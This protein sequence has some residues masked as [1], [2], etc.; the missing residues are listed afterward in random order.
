MDFTSLNETD[1]REEIIAPLIR[2][3]GYR[4]ATLHNVLREQ[5]LRYPRIYIGRKDEK[6][7]PPLRGKADYILEAGGV[8]RWVIEA[9]A[10]TCTI[11]ADEIE[12]AWTYANHP[13]VCA[14]YFSLCNGKRLHIYQT[15]RGP[16][17]VPILS[18]EYE[19]LS[20]ND[21]KAVLSNLLSPA[22]IL[23]DHPA[24]IVDI[25]PPIGPGL[26]SIARVTSG[27]FSYDKS[28][29][30]APAL[31]ELQLAIISGAV[32]R[33][34]DNRLVAF[35]E[36]RGPSRSIQ[37]FSER[38]GLSTFEMISNDSTFSTDTTHP[39][40]FTYSRSFIFPAGEE[41]LDMNTWQYVTL[42]S[43][44]SVKF[45]VTA[46]GILEGNKFHGTFSNNM[47]INEVM[48]IDLEGR[49]CIYVS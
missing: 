7:D 28:T 45:T 23:K 31:R 27:H 38:M 15:N 16:A 47:V 36:S 43:N 33:D 4:S 37:E 48:P 24:Q 30:E 1:V 19:Q 8:V 34:S 21:T 17:S 22:S 12:Q 44:M 49:F 26:R 14:V 41:L 35:L 9:K 18:V 40:T 29:L 10:P 13:E 25:R 32:E 42:P 39:T 3:L 2:E 20:D 5:S 11:D 46:S 6:K